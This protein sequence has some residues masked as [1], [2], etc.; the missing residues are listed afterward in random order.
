[1]KVSMMKGVST[2]IYMILCKVLF[3]KEINFHVVESAFACYVILFLSCVFSS[4]QFSVP[5]TG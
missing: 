5:I 1:M 2:L 3:Y 4:G